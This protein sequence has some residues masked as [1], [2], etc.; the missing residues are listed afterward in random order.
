[1]KGY[2]KQIVYWVGL[3]LLAWVISLVIRTYL[4]DTR[5]VPTGSMLPTIQIDDR[6]IVDK[7][8]FK[9]NTL[10]RGDVVVFNPPSEANIQEELVKRIIGLPGEKIAVHDGKVWINGVAL[11]ESYVM[12]LPDYEYQE[13]TIPENSYFM[14]GDNRSNSKDSHVWG[15]LSKDNISGMVLVR[16]W[17]LNS[18]G[19]LAGPESA[20]Y[21]L[22]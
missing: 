14:M 6:L 17:P 19:P 15:F 10:H 8:Y 18:M 22:Q 13:V 1:M 12:N 3:I 11:H 7:I 5:V 9:F 16:Y 4:I 20:D 2:F 21:G